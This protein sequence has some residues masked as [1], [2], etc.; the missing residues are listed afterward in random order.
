MRDALG[1]DACVF[2]GGGNRGAREYR[3]HFTYGDLKTKVPFDNEMSSFGCPAACYAKP[4]PRRV[5]VPP[6][7]RDTA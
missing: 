3:T 7:S 2:N 4:S 6:P 5:R 1:A